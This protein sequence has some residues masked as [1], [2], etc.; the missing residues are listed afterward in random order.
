MPTTDLGLVK[1]SNSVSFIIGEFP[2]P[3]TGSIST[4]TV[5]N[6]TAYVDFVFT[7]VDTVVLLSE[8][9]ADIWNGLVTVCTG[10]GTVSASDSIAQ[11]M[12]NTSTHNISYNRAWYMQTHPRLAPQSYE[13]LDAQFWVQS[14]W[15]RG[16]ASAATVVKKYPSDLNTSGILIG[17][18]NSIQSTID[19]MSDHDV[20]LSYVGGRSNKGFASIMIALE[21]FGDGLGIPAGMI[22]LKLTGAYPEYLKFMPWFASNSV[23]APYFTQGFT[24][25]TTLAPTT[26]PVATDK[27]AQIH[28]YVSKESASGDVLSFQL[29]S[30]FNEVS[31]RLYVWSFMYP[32]VQPGDDYLGDYGWPAWA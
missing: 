9:P 21:V 19:M 11:F 28:R 6:Y 13:G 22:P 20:Y 18:Y 32:T 25:S 29:G 2:E 3:S 7:G 24:K 14:T 1:G 16:T 30:S 10:L 4:V 8:D 23:I 5:E 31:S 17:P 26:P 27:Y 15:T 12:Y